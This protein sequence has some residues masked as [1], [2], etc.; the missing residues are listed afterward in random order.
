MKCKTP[1]VRLGAKDKHVH[2]PGVDVTLGRKDV[3]VMKEFT[4]ATDKGTG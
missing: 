3:I 4:L 1:V 2:S